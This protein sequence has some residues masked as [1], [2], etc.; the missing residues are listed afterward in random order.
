MAERQKAFTLI[1]FVIYGALVTI[2]VGALVLTSVNVLTGRAKIT[3]IEEVN[4]NA[5]FALERVMHEI[6]RAEAITLPLPGSFASSLNLVDADGDVRE[7]HLDQ[8]IGNALQLTI[9]NGTPV[10][11]TS[12]SVVVKNLKFTNVSQSNETPGTIRIEVTVAFK[13]PLERP[14]WDFE[15]TFHETENVRK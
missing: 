12:D 5:R 7:F 15:K 6:R 13:N 1:E 11:L 10:S 4:H 2:I 8:G 3:A 14:E 9:G